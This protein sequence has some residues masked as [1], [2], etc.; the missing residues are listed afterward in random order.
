MHMLVLS[1]HQ[2]TILIFRHR[3]VG[4]TPSGGLRVT[5]PSVTL[6]CV[7]AHPRKSLRLR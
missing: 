1:T 3:S 4:C 5:Q 2:V 7:Y 6:M